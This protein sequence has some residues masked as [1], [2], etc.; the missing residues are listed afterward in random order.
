MT[1]QTTLAQLADD[2]AGDEVRTGAIRS[3]AQGGPTDAQK[4]A[5]NYR[6]L[7]TSVHGMKIAIENEKGSDRTGTGADGKKWSVTMP[8]HYGYV[9]GTEGKDGDH[10]DVYLGPALGHPVVHV[11]DQIDHNTGAFDEH[12]AMVGFRSR[13]HA[14]DTYHQ[15]FSDGHGPDRVGAVTSLPVGKFK[16]WLA[17]GKRKAPL[18]KLAETVNRKNSVPWLAGA[19]GTPSGLPTNID[20]RLPRQIT[21]KGKTFSPDKYL[22]IH[23]T[24]EYHLMRKGTKY[25]PA[26]RSALRAEKAAVEADG[27][28]WDGYQEFMHR[29]AE[30]LEKAPHPNPPKNLYDKNYPKGMKASLKREGV[31]SFAE[32][33]AA[34][35]NEFITTDDQAQS[36]EAV[37]EADGVTEDDIRNA[38][39]DDGDGVTE[40]DIRASFSRPEYSERKQFG[41]RAAKAVAPGLAGLGP[42]GLGAGAGAMVAGPPGAVVGGLG[43]AVVSALTVSP[44]VREFQ[45]WLLNKLGM[46]ANPE[47]EAA[48]AQE[49]PYR[50]AAA[51]ILGG[52]A[53]MSP[54]QQGVGLGGRAVMGAAQAGFEGASQL[55]HGQGFDPTTMAMAAAAG[56][57][58]PGLNRAG[59][60][61]YGAGE[62]LGENLATRAGMARYAREPYGPPEMQGPPPRPGRPDLDNRGEPATSLEEWKATE[63]QPTGEPAREPGP[64]GSAVGPY[65]TQPY[66]PGGYQPSEYAPSQVTQDNAANPVRN[67][68]PVGPAYRPGGYRTPDQPANENVAGQTRPGTSPPDNTALPASDTT[69]NPAQKTAEFIARSKAHATPAAGSPGVDAS[70]GTAHEMPRPREDVDTV[71]S[72][73]DHPLSVGSER[74]YRTTTDSNVH[75]TASGS[76]S[77]PA[78][79]TLDP[80]QGSIPSDVMSAMAPDRS[81]FS[82]GRLTQDFL[83][84]GR[85]GQRPEV[86]NPRPEAPSPA[87][88]EAPNL[89]TEAP[90]VTQ[91]ETFTGPLHREV[92]E[93]P[94]TQEAYQQGH[95]DY[96][97]GNMRGRDQLAGEDLQAAWDRGANDAMTASRSPKEPVSLPSENAQTGEQPA[98]LEQEGP[99]I[100][101]DLTSPGFNH[102]LVD[103]AKLR[104]GQR[105]WERGNQTDDKELMDRAVQAMRD[106]VGAGKT[107]EQAEA[108]A[109]AGKRKGQLAR[110]EQDVTQAV[111]PEQTVT[112]SN[113]RETDLKVRA[114]DAANA[115]LEKFRPTG[116]EVIGLGEGPIKAL[117]ERLWSAIEHA[118][119]ENAGVNPNFTQS[120][121]GLREQQTPFNAETGEFAPAKPGNLRNFGKNDTPAQQWLLAAQKL[122]GTRE[123]PRK[124]SPAQMMKFMTDERALASNT[125]AAAQ[126]VRD[127]RRIEN[128][129]RAGRT[130]GSQ[131]RD[132]VDDWLQTQPKEVRQQWLRDHLSTKP[133]EEDIDHLNTTA[134]AAD[135]M[136]KTQHEQNLE[137]RM[138]R[139]I[140]IPQY[141]KD[142]QAVRAKI[143]KQRAERE[144]AGIK[145]KQANPWSDVVEATNSLIEDEGGKFDPTKAAKFLVRN[146]QLLHDWW[147]KQMMPEMVSTAA[148]YADPLIAKGNAVYAASKA[149]ILETLWQA[150]K[151]MFDRLGP[152][153]SL[154]Y[155]DRVEKGLAHPETWQQALNQ[156]MRGRLNKADQ[157]EK[158]YGSPAEYRENYLPHL[159][160]DQNAYK[161]FVTKYA[162]QFGPTWFE[163]ER[164]F[165]F[166]KQAIKPVEEGGPG[167]EL[168]YDNPVQM[169]QHR[170]IAG[171]N[172]KRIMHTLLDLSSMR[173][174]FPVNA[175]PASAVRGEWKEIIAP[176]G[177]KWLLSPDIQPLWETAMDTTK[178]LW[179][180]PDLLGKSYRGWMAYKSVW[181]PIT[182]GLS[183]F[184][185]L[186][187][188]AGV[189]QADNFTRGWKYTQGTVLDKFKGGTMETARNFADPYFALDRAFYW[190][191]PKIGKDYEG[192]LGRQALM[193]EPELR[194]PAQ[195]MAAQVLHESGTSLAP[196]EQE[197][198]D[199]SKRMLEYYDKQEYI[200]AAGAGVM[201]LMQ[202]MQKPAF[203]HMIPNLKAASI[204]RASKAY[205]ELHPEEWNDKFQRTLVHRTIGKEVE[206]RYGEMF[207]NNLFVNRMAKEIGIA[208]MLSLSWNLGFARHL[209]G[210]VAQMG[211]E[212]LRAIPGMNDRLGVRSG[213]SRVAY[214]AN[215]KAAYVMSYTAM[216]TAMAGLMSYG[217][218]GQAPT[219]PLDY[220]FPR[221]G[222]TNPDGSPR[223]VSTPFFTR[224]PVQVKGHAEG[225]GPG[226]SGLPGGLGEVLY[227]KMIV[228]P[229]VEAFKNR[230]FYGRELYDPSAPWLQQWGQLLKSQLSNHFNPIAMQGGQKAEQTG[231][232]FRD[233][234]VLPVLGLTPAPTY[235]AREP[236]QNRIAHL[237]REGPGAT[238]KPYGNRERDLERADAR[239][240]LAIAKQR[241]DTQAQ[242]VEQKRLLNTGLSP[243]SL[244]KEVYGTQDVYQFKQLDLNTKKNLL[245]EM[246][247][248]NYSR[249]VLKAG[250]SKDLGPLIQE[251]N[252][253]HK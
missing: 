117:Q 102:A 125:R 9:N 89:R 44:A 54:V 220:A 229:L 241:G 119:E 239:A 200:K 21:V 37:Q 237:F 127:L 106:A 99:R 85:Q 176:N 124:F 25:E 216:A 43:G 179:S 96:R 162:Q 14:I 92:P 62:R 103:E 52:M 83:N 28:D 128:D 204:L 116:D 150:E 41:I 67:P 22:V 217:L 55:V 15:S 60:V 115:A 86:M 153:A 159:F 164:T 140:E 38:F 65:E 221:V 17:K 88:N 138:T 154:D 30:R 246:S 167:L 7:H 252:R 129:I 205:F 20:H 46:N 133:T 227:N 97:A 190:F 31:R 199:W 108:E 24:H 33:G 95:R 207:Y 118:T 233:K 187:I 149:R 45:E 195:E 139:T 90:P 137:G 228:A 175:A 68:Q 214:Q 53:G 59:R 201:K 151:R 109:E 123:T 87:E 219:D 206:D 170:L 8:A 236:I 1:D 249:Y 163:K 93:F 242:A 157:E 146:R 61:P 193:V 42:V 72:N 224:E 81:T 183:F 210:G 26:H 39:R 212:A 3:F 29:F 32:G 143:E 181:A 148:R 34:D 209:T 111:S 208:S 226:L 225:H 19:S 130:S 194:T 114:A 218:S 178:S 134:R 73:P 75:P 182:L 69:F 135:D 166:I 245:K 172:M 222:G 180:N 161:A 142:A 100:L 5:G 197:W 57:A 78:A 202:D 13:K 18:G 171:E 243:E 82:P 112:G 66:Q 145:A 152:E 232:G 126:D 147:V 70:L 203:L 132:M 94:A 213:A 186:H 169:V 184:H 131:D 248:A 144:A 253:L 189:V 98:T 4:E 107:R 105:M 230:D 16:D 36:A 168:K 50:A 141:E 173:Q 240:R 77:Y 158:M 79:E 74:D 223:R 155:M 251:W 91:P 76:T 56:F 196:A 250:A 12:K 84:N 211:E 104:E 188:A 238:P 71:G 23:E 6:K 48:Y 63:W 120:R 51:D 165:D 231:G 215:S 234:Y 160:K 101:Q 177:Q 2:A 40:D 58:A 113:K 235:I 185:Q 136:N 10:V 244:S 80:T 27:I 110:E 191:G 47:E 49:H 11:V 192:K 35:D 122:V 156:D 198:H 247:P 64:P 174:A 121:K